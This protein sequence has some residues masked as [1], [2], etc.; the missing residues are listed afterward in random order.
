MICQ[1][2]VPRPSS[3][4]GDIFHK[5]ESLSLGVSRRNQYYAKMSTD[6]CQS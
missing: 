1:K 3:F 4:A 5:S 6:L 2:A